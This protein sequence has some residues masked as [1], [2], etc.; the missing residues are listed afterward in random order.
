[1][2]FLIAVVA[3]V[4]AWLS[5]S[6]AMALFEFLMAQRL[7]EVFIVPAYPAA[8]VVLGIVIFGV[9]GMFTAGAAAVY[10]FSLGEM[11]RRMFKPDNVYYR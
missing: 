5:G 1:M 7:Q 4:A 3:A 11:V 9:V 6:L 8:G 2:F 10:L